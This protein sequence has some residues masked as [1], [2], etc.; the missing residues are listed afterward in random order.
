[1]HTG[2]LSLLSLLLAVAAAALIPYV[3]EQV[4]LAV[5]LAPLL[6]VVCFGLLLFTREGGWRRS[7]GIKEWLLH[8]PVQAAPDALN[9]R[10]ARV[11]A[12]LLCLSASI[13]VGAIVGMILVPLVSSGSVA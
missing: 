6:V 11:P 1:M 2:P 4:A 5:V 12:V 13:A 3:S 8:G 10:V 9:A 7:H